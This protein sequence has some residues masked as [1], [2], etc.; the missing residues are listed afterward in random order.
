M[1]EKF[2]KLYELALQDLTENLLPWWMTTAVDNENGGWYGE[3]NN[4]D[5]PVAHAPKF[6]T[7]NA[8]LVWTFSSAYRILGDE[9]YKEMADRAYDYFIKHFWD[10][11]YDM[12]HTYVDEFGMP[13]D[14]HR[15]I[16]G[17]A[18]AIYGLSEYCRATA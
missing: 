8:R 17:N 11:R 3:V 7:L 16:Y 10:D 18:F 2:T 9:K 4:D 12:C 15:Y 5:K 1:N 14:S 13:I 6:I